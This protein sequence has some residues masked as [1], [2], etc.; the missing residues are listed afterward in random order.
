M[1]FGIAGLRRDA[2]QFGGAAEILR[3][4]LPFHV[5]Q[6]EIVSG[7]RLAELGRG[8]EPFGAGFAIARA[9][10][11]GETEHRQRE[12]R[13]AVAAIG[14]ELV[15]VRGFLVVLR[16]AEAAGIKL[17]E[18]RHR[19]RVA[20]VVD[21]FGGKPECG[22]II[23]ALI[24]AEREIERLAVARCWR[25]RRRRRRLCRRRLWVW[26]GRLSARRPAGSA[27]TASAASQSRAFKTP[28]RRD[29]RPR[30]SR[31]ALRYRCRC[32]FGC[33]HSQSP[34]ATKSAPACAR[35]RTSS[36]VAA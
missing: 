5:E 11:A 3:K 31:A 9:S 17:A 24:G 6:R 19:F 20:G 10:A 30:G 26:R 18:Q 22:E 34:R 29:R 28:A 2:Q 27:A 25:G 1:R 21:A 36:A 33:V 8:G 15:P 7:E 4:Q 14:G 35:G 32:A 16:H 12:H 13:L 23:A